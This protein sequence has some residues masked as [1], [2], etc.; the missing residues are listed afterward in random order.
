[1]AKSPEANTREHMVAGMTAVLKAWDKDGDGRLSRAE[2]QAMVDEFF[3]RV[4]QDS[5]G[6]KMTP[7][8]D[9]Q[10]QEFL[11]F[12][13]SQDTNDDGYLTLDE[14]LKGPLASFDCMDQNHDGK[15]SKEEVF[16][17][18]ERCPSVNLNDYAPK[19]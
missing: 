3:R 15:V 12:Y 1:M 8:L 10:R 18:M 4:A 13:A 6:G 19:P 9:K 11:A 7:D 17:G 16:S 5:S 14:L 2:V